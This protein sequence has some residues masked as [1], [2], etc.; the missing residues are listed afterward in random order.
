MISRRQLKQWLC[1]LAF[2]LFIPTF[3]AAQQPSNQGTGKSGVCP[4]VQCLQAADGGSSLGY[5][6]VAG[7]TCLGA[8]FLCG[9]VRKA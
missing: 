4:S 9:R 7:A 3:L 5:L 1:S 8:M 2:V 6:L